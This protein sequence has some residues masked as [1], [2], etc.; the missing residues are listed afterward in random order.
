MDK[1]AY[2]PA[3][4]AR[5][6][7][8]SKSR[9]YA[10]V[11]DGYLT[12]RRIG[13]RSLISAQQLD[14]WFQSL[15]HTAHIRKGRTMATP[16]A[17]AIFDRAVDKAFAIDIKTRA[18][19]DRA[20]DCAMPERSFGYFKDHL[21]EYDWVDGEVVHL[22]SG[23]DAKEWIAIDLRNGK[24]GYLW[25]SS[26]ADRDLLRKAFIDNNLTAKGVLYQQ[27]AAEISA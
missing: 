10:A 22:A 20:A 2:S 11:K 4:A 9:V 1:L 7:G 14:T 19:E 12:C 3:G 24:E 5:A 23:K 8:I 15:T 16:E 26:T 13:N 21:A 25:N 27:G 6:L 18:L 17:Q